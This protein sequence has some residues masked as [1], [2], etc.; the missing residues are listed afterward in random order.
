[1][2]EIEG[3]AVYGVGRLKST[4]PFTVNGVQ[5]V[6]SFYDYYQKNGD[7]NPDRGTAM[8]RVVAG[9]A[10][11]YLDSGYTAEGCELL[12]LA[13]E[14]ATVRFGYQGRTAPNGSVSCG[15]T[16]IDVIDAPLAVRKRLNQHWVDQDPRRHGRF[17]VNDNGDIVVVR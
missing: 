14:V 12:L 2:A 8:Y 6:G 9:V 7:R 15:Y 10:P 4:S 16:G 11:V 3:V 5:A 1:M 13:G 17:L